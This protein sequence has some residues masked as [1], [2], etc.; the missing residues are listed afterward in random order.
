MHFAELSQKYRQNHNPGHHCKLRGLKIDWPQMQPATRPINFGSDKLREDQKDDTGQI[1][2]QRAPSDPAVMDQTRHHE[3]KHTDSH[4]I[5]LLSPEVS[6]VR[7]G[8]TGSRAVDG[9][10]PKNGEREHR[11]QQKPILAEQFSQK[12][13]HAV[14]FVKLPVPSSAIRRIIRNLRCWQNVRSKANEGKCLTD[15]HLLRLSGASVER[16]LFLYSS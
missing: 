16:T 4:P 5:R 10:D 7:I 14:W 9:Y 15:Q 2:G 13:R 6:C 11:R 3:C 8:T 1:H 12:R